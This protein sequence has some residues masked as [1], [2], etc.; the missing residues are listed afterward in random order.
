MLSWDQP[1]SWQAA[2]TILSNT[3][4]PSLRPFPLP[5]PAPLGQTAKAHHCCQATARAL[6]V[7]K[8]GPRPGPSSSPSSVCKAH[9][10]WPNAPSPA[11]L[12]TCIS[13]EYLRTQLCYM[14]D[15][16]PS[17]P[18]HYLL[19]TRKA[20]KRCRQP[21]THIL[22]VWPEQAPTQGKEPSRYLVRAPSRGLKC[23]L[24]RAAFYLPQTP[25]TFVLF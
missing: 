4:P 19:K 22:E 17:P 12:R 2:G 3:S 1:L 9:T 11:E 16:T 6:H 24:E 23:I 18:L 10:Q 21:S 8:G 14:A 7:Q 13:P 25:G 20:L 15:L 5:H